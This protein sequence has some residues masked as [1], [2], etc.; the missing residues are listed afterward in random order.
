[1][2]PRGRPFPNGPPSL[3]CSGV[4]SFVTIA[5]GRDIKLTLESP[6][7][8]RLGFVTDLTR[9]L[10]DTAAGGREELR[11]QLQAANLSGRP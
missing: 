10:R 4:F 8:R 9:N 6:I 3:S 2:R 1:M 5:R 11:A 7:E